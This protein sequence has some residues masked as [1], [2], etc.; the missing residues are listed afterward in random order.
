MCEREREGW[1]NEFVSMECHGGVGTIFLLNEKKR[2][3]VLVANYLIW[4]A[5]RL[6]VPKLAH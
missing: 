1:L 2:V 5:Y 4:S 6:Q 3:F